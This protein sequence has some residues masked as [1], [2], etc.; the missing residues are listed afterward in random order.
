MSVLP[1]AAAAS[2]LLSVSGV[3]VSAFTSPSC[4]SAASAA[5]AAAACSLSSVVRH[6]L[7]CTAAVADTSGLFSTMLGSSARSSSGA[8]TALAAPADSAS[9][10]TTLL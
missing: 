9:S 8:A 6:A 3:A 2:L 5:A 1:L 10:A 7:A 4:G